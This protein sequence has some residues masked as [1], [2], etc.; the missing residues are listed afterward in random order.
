MSIAT[1][2]I[3]CYGPGNNASTASGITLNIGLNAVTSLG[4]PLTAYYPEMYATWST[5]PTTSTM[6]CTQFMVYGLN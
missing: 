2:G 3:F 5:G 6:Q 4:N 1:G